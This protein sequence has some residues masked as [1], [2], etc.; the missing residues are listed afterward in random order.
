MGCREIHPCRARCSVLAAWVSVPRV[1]WLLRVCEASGKE[2]IQ[3]NLCAGWCADC[4]AISG[5]NVDRAVRGWCHLQIHC[6][7]E[8]WKSA[9]IRE[10]GRLRDDARCGICH[11]IW[12]L[13]QDGDTAA[14]DRLWRKADGG[15][16]DRYYVLWSADCII[17]SVRN[18]SDPVAISWKADA[19]SRVFVFGICETGI[20]P[21]AFC[22]GCKFG[23]CSG[24]QPC[25]CR[26]PGASDDSYDHVWLYLCDDRLFGSA[27]VDVH[28][29]ISSDVSA[30]AGAVW[31]AGIGC[32]FHWHDHLSV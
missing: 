29:G 8:Y 22:C 1:Q 14:E 15:A 16:D 6:R 12:N 4:T 28:S 23:N 25:I 30:C 20:L 5:F 26:K 13:L 32:A 31:T 21:V 2:K 10:S 27:D 3:G 19:A 7:P 11:R 24:L 9:V 17:C 18:H